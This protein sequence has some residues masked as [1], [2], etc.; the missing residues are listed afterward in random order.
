MVG[1]LQAI[2]RT[3]LARGLK[4][5]GRLLETLSSTGNH[6]VEGINFVP[7]GAITKREFLENYRELV[8]DIFQPEA[9][10]ER[11]VPAFLELQVKAPIDSLRRN[12]LKLAEVL[13]KEF[14]YF[15]FRAKAF[16]FHF[17]RAFWQIFRKRP[18]A[19]ESFVFDCAVF[20]HLYQHAGYIQHELARYLAAPHPDDVLDKVVHHRDSL[21][22]A[23]VA[24]RVGSVGA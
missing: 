2:P 22:D 18:D 19:L 12:G 20:H 4:E 24:R 9:Y 16:R 5:E 21:E 1:L 13:V 23:I 11:T 7:K 8:R 14:Y 10:F 17:W 6:T 15:G 3:Q